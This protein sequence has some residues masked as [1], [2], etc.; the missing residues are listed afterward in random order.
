MK[1]LLKEYRIEFIAGGVVL[2]GILLMIEPFDIREALLNGLT[3][4]ANNIL[5]SLENL[6]A[7]VKNPSTLLSTSDMLGIILV[8]LAVGFIVWRIRFRFRTGKRWQSGICPKCSSQIMR[9][10]R[11]WVDRL[12]GVTLPPG[13]LTIL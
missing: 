10:H 5:N 8:L 6:L 3:K 9:V 13:L 12:L 1:R 2:I 4:F 11:N 7:R